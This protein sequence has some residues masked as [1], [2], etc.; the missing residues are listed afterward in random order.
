M[1]NVVLVVGE[2][3]I[4]TGG[5]TRILKLHDY[6]VKDQHTRTSYKAAI[7]CSPSN[8]VLPSIIDALRLSANGNL[9]LVARQETDLK[10]IK[11]RFGGLA[12]TILNANDCTEEQ[13]LQAVQT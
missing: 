4:V 6:E 1:K 2:P 13:L 10:R 8:A 3:L 7:V 12:K 9:I 11:E 5:I